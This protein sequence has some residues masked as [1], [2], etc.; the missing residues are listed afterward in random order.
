M[1]AL[2]I[3]NPGNDLA[4]ASGQRYY[5]PP[6]AA[7]TLERAGVWLPL[8]LGE[9]GD[10]ILAE[11]ETYIPEELNQHWEHGMNLWNREPV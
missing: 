2:H 9:K 6:T 11:K 4:L 10:Y 1:G 5:T 3:F 8:L 7:V